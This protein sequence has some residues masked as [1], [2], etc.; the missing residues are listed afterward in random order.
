MVTAQNWNWQTVGSAIFLFFIA[1]PLS[2]MLGLW[3]SDSSTRVRSIVGWFGVRGI[4]SIYYLMYAINH[5]LPKNLVQDLIQVTIVVVMLSIVVHG[6]SVK[7]LL[8]KFWPKRKRE[9]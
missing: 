6:T 9:S 2:V 5:G 7:P 4:G 1:R 3:G 8:D